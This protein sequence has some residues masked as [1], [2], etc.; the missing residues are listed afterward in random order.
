MAAPSRDLASR[1]A[2]LALGNAMLGVGIAG[3]VRSELGLAPWDVFHQGLSRVT[4]LTIGAA[5]VVTS[6][7]L[8]ALW[9]PLRR[10]P[11]IGT[12]S[13]ALMV[14]VTVDLVLEAVPVLPADAW[15]RWLSLAIGLLVFGIGS[16][17]YIGA[18]LGPG[19]RDGIMTGIAERGPSIRVA[20][21]ALEVLALAAGWILGGTVG[22]GTLVFAVG[23]G[24][25]VQFWLARFDRSLPRTTT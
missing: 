8:L 12:I 7:A 11:G 16:G 15:A 1:L 4:P 14:G 13:N 25:L 9:L 18:R 22:V 3:F 6:F 19:P 5:T 24:P 21:T 2:Q 23:V 17:L 20:R 10:R